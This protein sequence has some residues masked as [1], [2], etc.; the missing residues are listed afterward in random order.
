MYQ[1]PIINKRYDLIEIL[2]QLQLKCF[3]LPPQLVSVLIMAGTIFYSFGYSLKFWYSDSKINIRYSFT[4]SEL[5][6]RNTAQ[7]F[8][9][10]V[11]KP[12]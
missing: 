6:T 7:K 4:L 12:P 9:D 10:A 5:F 2:R 11:D 3:V 8:A 1:Y